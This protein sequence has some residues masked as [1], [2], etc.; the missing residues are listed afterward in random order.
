MSFQQGLSG[1][2]SAAKG[3]DVTSNNIANSSTV[4][5]KSAAAHFADVYANSLS[6]S[7]ASQV[8]IGT[9]TMAV[10]QSFTQGNV[11]TSNNPLDIAI[12]GGGFYRMSTNGTITYSRNGQFHLDKNGFVVD[13]R[14]RVLTGYPVDASTGR[15]VQSSPV[16]LQLDSGDQ[17]PVA[18][19]SGVGASPGVKANVNLDSRATTT[20]WIPANLGSAGPPVVPA[21][22]VWSPSPATYNWST[23]LSIYDSL[24]NGHTL[25]L[26]AVKTVN[27][28]EWQIH[29]NVD[30]TTDRE[31]TLTGSTLTFDTSGSLVGSSVVNASIDLAAVMTD[32]GKVNSAASPL[33]FTID[34]AGSSQYGSPFGANRLEQDGYTSGRLTGVSVAGDGVLRGNYSNGQARDLGQ[35]VL[36]GFTNPNGLSSLGANQWSE[37]AASGAALVGAPGSAS[38][39]VLQAAAI[40]ESNTDL[41]AEL[42]NMITQ[43]RNYQANAQSIKTQDQILQ[44]L[45]NLR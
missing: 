1:L 17:P 23:A 45:V 19:G 3:L 30:G 12:N 22:T 18:T 10:Q 27:P 29:A 9:T 35:V 41:T 32:L 44:T 13:D 36:A 6:G 31:V 34:F 24:G 11:T 42:V 38:L 25:S 7:G 21:D 2:N 40:E 15:V 4:G 43:Q 20:T 5:F 26:Y 37:T 8:G 39:G 28:R 14:A 16:E 33:A